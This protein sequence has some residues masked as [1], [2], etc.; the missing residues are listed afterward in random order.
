MLATRTFLA[1]VL[2]RLCP[3]YPQASRATAAVKQRAMAHEVEDA[4]DLT[5]LD[6]DEDVES[7]TAA[8]AREAAQKQKIMDFARAKRARTGLAAGG[9]A[10]SNAAAEAQAAAAGPSTGQHTPAT[11]DHRPAGATAAGA[12]S[13]AAGGAGFG[14]EDLKA[15]HEARMQRLRAQK[16]AAGSLE[17]NSSDQEAGG[18][19]RGA[20]AA[21]PSSRDA[22]PSWFADHLS[23]GSSSNQPVS[24]LTYNVW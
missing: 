22:T 2:A 10:N 12:A 7:P 5:G 9:Q 20:A 6:S 4:I 15:L 8:A 1:P 13:A 17:S 11:R 14:N 18:K 3:R 23:G 19:S 16:A 24:L 21:A